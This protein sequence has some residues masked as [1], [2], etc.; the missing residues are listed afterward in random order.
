[1]AESSVRRPMPRLRV[2]SLPAGGIKA[3]SVRAVVRHPRA[4]TGAILTVLAIGMAA[5]GSVWTPYDPLAM[6]T[7][8]AFLAPS[9]H[10]L[11]GTD[12][13]GRDIFSRIMAGARISLS[14]AAGAA[15]GALVVGTVIGLCAGF[16]RGAVDLVLTRII[17]LM[18]AI[19]GLVM[20]LGIVV[21]LS[22]SASS[23]TVALIAV[24]S[25]QF[26]RIVRSA[27]VSVRGRPYV[28]AARGL[29]VSSGS[30]LF[31]DVFP[32][33]TPVLVVQLATAFAWGVLDEASLG[34]LGL[35][36][37]PPNPSWGSLLIEGRQ[38]MYDAPWLSIG[39]GIMVVLA[40]F[41]VNLLGDGL[42]DIVDPRSGAGK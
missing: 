19:P 3:I 36:V 5:V 33:V 25:W 30:V 27:V 6:N 26:A 32:S 1:M 13:F 15:L 8:Q 42:N 41:G 11:M 20:A 31:R 9:L 17:D 7:S 22:P 16:F 23:V 37:Q 18:L 34:F 12:V 38:Y 21:L 24:Y 28:E 29:G 35:G 39:A 14:V 2:R 4:L 40:V 10:H